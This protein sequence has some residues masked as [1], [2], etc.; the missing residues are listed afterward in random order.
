MMLTTFDRIERLEESSTLVAT[1]FELRDYT[2]HPGRRDPLIALFE[3]EF[4]EAQEAVGCRVLAT[5][6]DL[7]RADHFVWLRGFAGMDARLQALEAFY[8]GPVWAAHRDVA[9]ATMIDSDEVLLLHGAGKT[10]VL[11]PSHPDRDAPIPRNS[12][13]DVGIFALGD[14]DENEFARL[15]ARADGLVAT[16]ATERSANNFPRLPVRSDIVFVMMRKLRRGENRR[17][18]LG[19]SNPIRRMR[20]EP[21]ARSRLR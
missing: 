20:L 9:N 7:D 11:L 6:R 14:A 19:L 16:F 12:V 15:A 5:F 2:L 18:A 13:V 10:P 1:I 21:T 17:D 4:V 3:R 8:G